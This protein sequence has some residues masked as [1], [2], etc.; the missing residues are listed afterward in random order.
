MSNRGRGASTRASLKHPYLDC[1]MRLSL[2]NR[3]PNLNG[4]GALALTSTDATKSPV[5]ASDVDADGCNSPWRHT[6]ASWRHTL[7]YLM[8]MIVGVDLL[9]VAALAS[10]V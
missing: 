1:D 6:L 9:I 5:S 8:Y 2:P 7:D 10:I 3:A 4:D